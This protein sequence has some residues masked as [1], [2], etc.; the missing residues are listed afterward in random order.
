MTRTRIMAMA[1][2]FEFVAWS[3][4]T[5][6]AGNIALTG[7]DDDL[8][9]TLSSFTDLAPGAQL[10]AMLS[11]VR[12]GS[13]LPVL[14]FDANGSGFGLEL[15][16]ALT[17]LGIAHTTINPEI[18][19]NVTD[20]LFNPVLYSAF[21][22]ASDITCSGCDLDAAGEANIAA[23]STAVGNFLNAGGGILG[24]AGAN[25]LNYY[26]FVPQTASSVGGAPSNG[27][28]QTAVGATLG[29]PAVNGDPTHNLFWNPG[30]HGESSSFQIAEVN[31]IGN[32]TVPAPAATTLVCVACTV[33]GGV[34]GG[35]V[36]EPSSIALFGTVLLGVAFT[37]RRRSANA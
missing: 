11:F 28:S 13:S 33:S 34:I 1:V 36:P 24:L 23:H 29:I 19:G 32:G 17:H 22:V 37:L 35:G 20:A 10:S 15:D 26:A 25:S 30:T 16:A 27:Y 4:R 9:Y 5:A 8:H 3:A 2:G 31:S 18:A 6:S 14:V 21:A 7:H 12:N